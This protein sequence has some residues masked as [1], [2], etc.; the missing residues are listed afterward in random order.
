MMAWGAWYHDELDIILW[1]GSVLAERLSAQFLSP[2]R[3]ALPRSPD[4]GP[5]SARPAGRG[6]DANDCEHPASPELSEAFVPG[7]CRCL[8][9]SIGKTSGSYL[10]NCSAQH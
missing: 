4:Q 10:P 9:L 7:L 6:T 2:L 5:L 8:G 3:T 1:K